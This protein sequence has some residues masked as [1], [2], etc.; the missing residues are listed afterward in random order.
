MIR[1]LTAFGLLEACNPQPDP[2]GWRQERHS[3]EA[4]SAEAEAML[5]HILELPRGEGP[6]ASDGAAAGHWLLVPKR[7]RLDAGRRRAGIVL[8]VVAVLAVIAVVVFVALP[9][10]PLNGPTAG[11]M[12]GS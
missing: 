6:S 7:L 12:S 9:T 1:Q 2:T 4:L 3:P 10:V 8:A 11:S 5:A